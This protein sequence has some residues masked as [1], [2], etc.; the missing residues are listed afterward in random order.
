[1]AQGH[2][3]LIQPGA[4]PPRPDRPP[5]SRSPLFPVFLFVS[6]LAIVFTILAVRSL[7]RGPVR[8]GGPP[9]VS[10]TVSIAPSPSTSP[11][12]RPRPSPQLPAKP[13]GTFAFID[14]APEG[15]PVRWDPCEPITYAV[16]RGG[17]NFDVR[18]D[19]Q[20]ALD[21]VTAATGIRFQPV[22]DTNEGF[23]HAWD[24]MRFKGVIG[25]AKLIVIWVDH[26]DYL[27][28]LRRLGDRQP[29]TA[30]AK[31]LAGA[32][33]DR[34]QYFGGLILVDA[35]LASRP[36][37]ESTTSHGLVL[38]HELGHILGLA[39]VKDPN[40]VMYS[41]PD[42]NPALRGYGQGDLAGLRQL[43]RDAGCLT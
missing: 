34:D 9:P 40:Q 12:P 6:A 37:F 19:L 10:Q 2:L 18:S 24:R 23:L 25:E 43:G 16:N 8:A 29:S 17:A 31:P 3:P 35:D 14:R 21:R 33:Q 36:G 7:L 39:H 15:G 42:P 11:T 1:M 26:A 5:I 4:P 41:G 13:D 20:E 22:G 30:L 28:T 32:Y 38:L 27:T